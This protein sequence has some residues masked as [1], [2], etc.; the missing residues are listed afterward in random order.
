M[1]VT[2]RRALW[3]DG[4]CGFGGASYHLVI[5]E[6]GGLGAAPDVWRIGALVSVLYATIAWVSTRSPD[7]GL[8]RMIWLNRAWVVA[9]VL[10]A[11]TVATGFARAMLAGEAVVVGALSLWE[12]RILKRGTLS[13]AR[14]R[15]R[16]PT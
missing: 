1:S 7:A 11:A 4:A 6:V 8:T 15:R 14:A 9:C 3:I 5:A 16:R 10:G 13:S 2:P 12:T